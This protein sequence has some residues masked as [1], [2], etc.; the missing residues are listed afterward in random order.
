VPLTEL[1]GLSVKII[2]NLNVGEEINHDE[3]ED[4]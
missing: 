3:D 2:E 4:E 1:E